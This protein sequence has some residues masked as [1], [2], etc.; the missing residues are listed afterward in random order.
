MRKDLILS[1]VLLVT[2][3]SCQSVSALEL[4]HTPGLLLAQSD[5]LDDSYDPFADYSEFEEAAQEE[6]DIH[7]FR[8]GRFFTFGFV[9]GMR[10]FTGAWGTLYSQSPSF[11]ANITYFFDM[12]FALQ[13]SYLVSSHA[14]TFRGPLTSLAGTVDFSQT[15]FHLKYFVNPQNMTRGLANLNPYVIGGFSNFYRGYTFVGEFDFVKNSAFG[16]DIGAG[17]E[18]PL[19]RNQMFLGIEG[20][21]HLVNFT[22]ENSPIYLNNGTENTGIF[23]T[24]DVF[25]LKFILGINF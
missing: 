1:F 24:G 21:F 7:F 3:L 10:N 4:S 8:N 23:P 17:I 2:V 11:G 6:A 22:D 14:F 25:D 18:I 12:R 19:M 13:V 15:S 20:M 5:M 16:A 9:G